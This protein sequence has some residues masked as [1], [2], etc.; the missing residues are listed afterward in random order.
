MSRYALKSPPLSLRQLIALGCSLPLTLQC[1]AEPS[2]PKLH[3]ASLEVPTDSTVSEPHLTL[4]PRD[5]ETLVA[6]AQ[7]DLFDRPRHLLWRSDDG[8]VTWTSP[9]VMGGSDNSEFG[10]AADPVVAGGRGGELVFAG[11]LYYGTTSVVGTRVS[12]ND[13]VSFTAFG[14]AE[15]VKE[16]KGVDKPWVAVDQSAGEFGGRVYLAWLYFRTGDPTSPQLRF[17][18][19]RDGGRTYG[20]PLVLMRTVFRGFDDTPEPLAQVAVRPD[21]TV[22]VVWNQRRSG[23]L[24]I[25]HAFST[26]GGASFSKSEA[27]ARLDASTNAVGIVSSLAVSPSGRLAVCWSQSVS[28]ATYDPRVLCAAK[29]AAGGWDEPRAILPES[30]DSQYLPAAAFQGERLW[31]ASYVSDGARTRLVLVASDEGDASFGT[32]LTVGSWNLGDDDICAPHPPGA[33]CGSEQTFIGDYMGLVAAPESV[34]VAYIAPALPE[35]RNR[36][37]VSSLRTP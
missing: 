1:D 12:N 33:D 14:R 31:A 7:I 6:V 5:P 23:A 35:T 17:A 27:V 37:F 2:K 10:I 22:D 18:V 20:S 8:G 34:S 19:S 29:E 4:D 26:D 15:T 28:E 25:W 21:G 36:M 16:P 30:E 32:P 9:L 11:L 13:G 3:T 24:G